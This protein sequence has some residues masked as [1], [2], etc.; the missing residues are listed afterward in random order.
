MSPDHKKICLYE[1]YNIDLVD[2]EQLEDYLN[3]P[4]SFNMHTFS[5]DCVYDQDDTQEEVYDNTAKDAVMSTLEGF[6]ATIMAYG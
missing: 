3:N 4:N 5:F 1:Y 6:N 2:P